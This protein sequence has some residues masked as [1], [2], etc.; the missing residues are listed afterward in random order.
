MGF[1]RCAVTMGKVEVPDADEG[2]TILPFYYDIVQKVTRHN[3]NHNMIGHESRSDTF[4]IR[5]RK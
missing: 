5:T 2:R 3:M 4:Q 1:R